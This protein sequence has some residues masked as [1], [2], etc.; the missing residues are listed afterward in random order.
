MA[1]SF[2]RYLDARHKLVAVY[3]GLRGSLASEVP[4]SDETVVESA[5]GQSLDQIDADFVVSFRK[6]PS[7][8]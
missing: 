8:R 7:T 2:V 5:I 1:A 3:T 6:Q 4:A